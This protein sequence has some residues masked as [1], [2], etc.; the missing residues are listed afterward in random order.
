MLF[1]YIEFSCQTLRCLHFQKSLFL[2]G[3]TP[4]PVRKKTNS[5]S[6]ITVTAAG[7]T[8]NKLIS[9]RNENILKRVKKFVTWEE[10]WQD[11]QFLVY[12]LRFFSVTEKVVLAQVYSIFCI[13]IIK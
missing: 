12:F 3:G 11:Y 5:S 2:V 8:C 6:A 1:P 4:G 7:L 13:N 10:L 9:Q